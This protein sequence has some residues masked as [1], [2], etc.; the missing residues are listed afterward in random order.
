MRGS[1]WERWSW[2]E[3]GLIPFVSG[4]CRAS[5]MT[6]LI[7]IVLNN[8]LVAPRGADYPAWLI[9]LILLA[10]SVARYALQSHPQ[11][12]V[13]VVLGGL[14]A[15]SGAFAYHLYAQPAFSSVRSAAGLMLSLTDFRQGIPALLL[16]LLIT[17]ALWRRGMT[18]EWRS[19][20]EFWRDFMIGV[21][22]LGLLLILPSSVLGTLSHAALGGFCVVFVLTGLLSLGLLGVAETLAV[23]R[24]HDNVTSPLN[25]YWL[26]AVGSVVLLI[27]FLGWAMSQLLSPGAVAE[28]WRVLQP[29]L[30]FVGRILEYVLIAFA[31]LLTLILVPI[32]RAFRIQLPL[33]RPELQAPPLPQEPAPIEGTLRLAPALLQA[34]RISLLFAIVAGFVLAFL[35]VRQRLRERSRDSVLEERELIWSKEL[36]LRQ[37]RDL[38]RRK[39]KGRPPLPFVALP[40]PDEPRQ[41]IRLIYQQLLSRARDLGYARPPGLT[42]RRYQRMLLDVLPDQGAALDTLT[43]LYVLARYGPSDPEPEDVSKARQAMASLQSALDARSPSAHQP[44]GRAGG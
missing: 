12:P 9:L 34:L 19:F 13:L 42:P 22:I 26:T 6:P 17:S 16:I 29:T 5:W 3:Q 15:V 10:A 4:I 23:E 38:L 24:V 31:Y 35:V 14:V 39:P 8:P 37:L 41:A 36:L 40:Y 7:H 20:S 33:E 32:F 30:R 25:R 18:I 1:T 28:A 11:G 44:N 21:I 2:L 27:T 43:T